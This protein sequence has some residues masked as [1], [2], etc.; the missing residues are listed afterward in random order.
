M[1]IDEVIRMRCEIVTGPVLRREQLRNQR[2]QS[3]NADHLRTL[4][5]LPQACAPMLAYLG[6]T[7]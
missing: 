5:L 7:Q 3:Y 4:R 1:G 2:W 6:Q